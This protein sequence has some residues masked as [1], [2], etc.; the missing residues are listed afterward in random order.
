MTPINFE[1][2]RRRPTHLVL[3]G[4]TDLRL[5]RAVRLQGISQICTLTNAVLPRLLVS[6]NPIAGT[7][8]ILSTSRGW[9]RSGS[10]VQK[11]CGIAKRNLK[12]F[13]F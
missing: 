1:L 13:F 12:D 10:G 2:M 4:A 7:L 11:S 5:R 6:Y 8:Y 3:Q 9:Q